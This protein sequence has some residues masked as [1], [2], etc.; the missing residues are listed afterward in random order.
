M[1]VSVSLLAQYSHFPLTHL[2]FDGIESEK[3]P[4]FTSEFDNF[5][6]VT[7]SSIFDSWTVSDFHSDLIESSPALKI[8]NSHSD[9][10]TTVDVGIS[11]KGS[12]K[13][14]SNFAYSQNLPD[15][16]SIISPDTPDLISDIIYFL[17]NLL[18]DGNHS[19]ENWLKSEYTNNGYQRSEIYFDHTS[20]ERSIANTIISSFGGT[21]TVP[22]FLKNV[23][24]HTH[25]N[26]STSKASSNKQFSDN[27]RADITPSILATSTLSSNFQE[28]REFAALDV[29]ELESSQNL[30]SL[31]RFS[32]RQRRVNVT[33]YWE[34]KSFNGSSSENDYLTLNTDHS[35][36]NLTI[37]I[38]PL[39]DGALQIGDGNG[40]GTIGAPNDWTDHFLT[41]Q[42]YSDIVRFNNAG[43]RPA[44]GN[45]N[46]DASAI[47]YYMNYY[48]GDWGIV[49]YGNNYDLM[50]YS[51]APEPS[52]Y[53]MTGALL[54]FIGFNQK[55]RKSLKK[56]FNLLSI[57][58]NLPTCIEKLTRSQSHS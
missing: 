47:E 14:D 26:H 52:T 27:S 9:K 6:D 38:R 4:N 46:V 41:D 13:Q 51:Q 24:S 16:Y 15:A 25:H 57:K 34:M 45:I 29:F 36:D 22:E 30:P 32:T 28:N 20:R 7:D 2:E 58:L 42:T 23:E 53:V 40:S 37:V 55:S 3:F 43:F 1:A 5:E 18:D 56:I 35:S 49:A 31:Q 10:P 44:T 17:N 33:Y 54:C 8:S 11:R 19:E 48:Y 12:L 50:Y 39:S 21:L